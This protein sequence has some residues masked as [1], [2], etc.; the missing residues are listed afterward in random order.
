MEPNKAVRMLL[1]AIVFSTSSCG[2]FPV[3][4]S[5][6]PDRKHEIRVL[7][8]LPGFEAE[9][10]VRVEISGPS[11]QATIFSKKRTAINFVEAQWLPDSTQVGVLLC[12]WWTGPFIG[13]YDTIRHRALDG[14]IFKSAIAQQV[15]DKYSVP[16]GVDP[17]RWACSSDG[18]D[19]Y[20]RLNKAYPSE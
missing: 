11:D 17:I 2:Y 19:E 5:Q 14:N 6:S 1:A 7:R 12:G 16:P 4:R 18:R 10:A 8:N 3:F 15:R 13:G 20:R 9:Y